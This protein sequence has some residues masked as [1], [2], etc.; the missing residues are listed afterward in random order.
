MFEKSDRERLERLERT[1]NALVVALGDK[2]SSTAKAAW[3]FLGDARGDS[4]MN[5]AED[6]RNYAKQARDNTSAPEGDV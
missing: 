5:V 3:D 1:V 6:A 2:T 4:L